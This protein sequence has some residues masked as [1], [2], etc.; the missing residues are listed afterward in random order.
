QSPKRKT[1]KKLLELYHKY[2]V[3]S[4]NSNEDWTHQEYKRV[5]IFY[6]ELDYY[7]LGFIGGEEKYMFV[8]GVK[9]NLIKS[10][11]K[12]L[13]KGLSCKCRKQLGYPKEFFN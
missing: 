3:I 13:N 11:L 1:Q 10:D 6:T 2:D 7:Y 4:I 9:V 5:L 12:L 8:N